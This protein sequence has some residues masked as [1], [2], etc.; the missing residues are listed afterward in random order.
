MVSPTSA[1]PVW[2]APTPPTKGKKKAQAAPSPS[3]ATS[4]KKEKPTKKGA[5]PSNPL[6]LHLA[7]TFPQEGKPDRYLMTVAILDATAAHIIG[8]GGK[9]LKQVH[10]ISGT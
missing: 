3:K 9:G 4:A 2:T 6:P 8:Q 10:N 1:T 5:I 7:Q